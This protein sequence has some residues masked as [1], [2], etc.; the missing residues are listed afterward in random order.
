MY[1]R[2]YDKYSK[3]IMNGGLSCPSN[4]YPQIIQSLK[5]EMEYTGNHDI[6]FMKNDIGIRHIITYQLDKLG[7][8]ILL[9]SGGL[10]KV[11]KGQTTYF[12]NNVIDKKTIVIK[13]MDMNEEYKKNMVCLE[14]LSVFNIN[15]SNIIRYY[16]YAE[17]NDKILIFMEFLDG[18][19]L[20]HSLQNN[21]LL[22]SEKVSIA[23]QLLDGLYYLHQNNICHRDIKPENIM[24]SRKNNCEIIAKYID[25]NFSCINNFSCDE[26]RFGQG[27]FLYMSPELLKTLMNIDTNIINIDMYQYQYQYHDL[28]ALGATIYSIFTG[29][30]LFEN[31]NDIIKATQDIIDNKIKTKIPHHIELEY[32]RTNIFNLLKINPTDRK[33]T[34]QKNKF[35]DYNKSSDLI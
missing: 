8:K 32:V 35:I 19:D 20:L 31:K 5:D 12:S 6:G 23:K 30:L 21:S 24:I 2:K 1:K 25:F 34:F 16:G 13:E 9:G 10:G 18:R 3:K 22:F 14:L 17:L 33:I 29:E 27:T 28:W 4:L 26:A 11:Y 15:H 7:N